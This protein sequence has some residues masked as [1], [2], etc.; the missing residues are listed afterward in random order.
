[1]KKTGIAW[2]AA[3]LLV[4]FSCSQALAADSAA[5]IRTDASVINSSNIEHRHWVY[6]ELAAFKQCLVPVIS[7]SD[8]IISGAEKTKLQHIFD[9][10]N[11]DQAI[12]VEHWALLLKIVLGLPKENSGQLL[13]MYVFNLT[14]GKTIL[15]ED[16]A[17]G[18]VKLLTLRHLSGSGSAEELEPSKAIVDLDKVSE[19]QRVLVQK[20]YCE[21]LLD[22]TVKV[23]F[24]PRVELTNAEAVSMLY[25]VI[26]K[27]EIDLNT[28]V[29]ISMNRVPDSGLKE[30]WAAGELGNSLERFAEKSKYLKRAENIVIAGN[31]ENLTDYLEQPISIDCWNELI[32][33]TLGLPNE[34][35][36]EHFLS[37][38][39][40]GVSDGKHIK[41]SNAVAGMVKLLHASQV[42][43]GRDATEE[44]RE[45]ASKSFSDYDN[46]FD[47][48]KFAIAYNEGLIRGYGDGAFGCHS[49]LTRGEALALAV[50]VILKYPVR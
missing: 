26:N 41:R 5:N 46:A 29:N 7:Y 47:K 17:G 14:S 19:R 15:R 42:V 36:D 32:M 22:S 21:G 33:K 12:E 49:L 13:D 27:Y 43:G 37:G 4:V 44:E 1:M 18:M 35:F 25:R 40:Y 48:S 30:H 23:S 20:A 31:I 9:E 10:R 45:A 11:L 24:R 16:A 34:Y 6:D 38:Y 39:T 3:A 2:L 8:G 50:R 28:P